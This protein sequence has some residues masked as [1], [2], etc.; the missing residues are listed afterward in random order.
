M[1]ASLT[2]V[3]PRAIDG[4][5]LRGLGSEFATFVGR[6]FQVRSGAPSEWIEPPTGNQ[7]ACGGERIGKTVLRTFARGSPLDY[8]AASSTSWR[9]LPKEFKKRLVQGF[10]AVDQDGDGK[11]NV[12]EMHKLTLQRAQARSESQDEDNAA[13]AR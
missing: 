9:E 13:G 8:S 11:L 10:K 2:R 4:S 12:D 3:L 1:L 5:P 7:V 6:A